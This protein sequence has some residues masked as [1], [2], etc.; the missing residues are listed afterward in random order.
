MRKILIPTKLDSV[1]A[2]LLREKGFDVIQDTDTPLDELVR[3]HDDAAGLI[4]RNEKITA[5]VID[6]L[7][8]LKVIVRAGAGYDNIDIKHARRQGIDV[9]NTPGAN[10]NAVA[11][12]VIALALAAYRHVVPGDASTRAG[13]WEKKDYM[14][15]EVARKTVGIVGLGN[16]GQLVARRLVGFEPRLLAYDPVVSAGKAEQL[17]IEL[18]SLEDLFAQSDIIT[19]HLPETDDTRGMINRRLLDLAKPG[20]MLINCAR[21]G[22]VNED[23]IRAI[24]EEKELIFC[25]DVYPKDAAGD[26]SVADIADIML[27]HLG[28][29]T[30]EANHNAARRAAEQLTAILEHGSSPYVVNLAIPDGLDEEHV[31]LAFYLA[32]VARGYLGVDAPPRRLE[33]SYYGGLDDYSNWLLAPIVSGMCAHFD[34][35]F[36]YKDAAE[37]LEDKGIVYEKRPFDVKKKYGRS[38]TIDLFEGSGTSFSKVSV[39]G[40]LAESNPMVS[41]IDDFDKLYFDPKGYSV[42]VVYQDRP[43]VLA[44]ITGVMAKHGINIDDIRAPNDPR[45]GE[46]MAVLKVNAAVSQVMLDEITAEVDARKAAFV[47]IS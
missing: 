14:G 15:R 34:A 21:A 22:V 3:D 37:Y 39:R 26:K 42:L 46:S 35:L 2:E 18:C 32:K 8:I 19:L 27:P 38:M 43:G 44:K 20:M 41:R 12:E 47:D 9:M 1:A 24:K 45:T 5:A 23:D 6:A 25:N 11:E 29:S 28:A 30:R 10:A 31:L 13:L 40:T 4:V 36:D 17:E 7:P 16:I 33:V